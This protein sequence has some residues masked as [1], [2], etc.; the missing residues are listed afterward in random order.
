MMENNEYIEIFIKNKYNDIVTE[1][2]DDINIYL[3]FYS[4]VPSND[5]S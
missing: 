4:D 3:P 2:K 5:L 1:Y